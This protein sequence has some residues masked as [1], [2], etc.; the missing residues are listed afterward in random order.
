MVNIIKSKCNIISNKFVKHKSSVHQ[1]KGR[2]KKK[3]LNRLVSKISTFFL[4]VSC[5]S[6][7]IIATISRL[8]HSR[9]DDSMNLTS[10]VTS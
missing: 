1:N 10:R 7:K 2:M 9:L 6:Y 3:T 8:P 5:V 4:S